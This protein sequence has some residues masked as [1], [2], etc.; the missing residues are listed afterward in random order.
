MSSETAYQGPPP[1][2]PPPPGWRIETVVLPAEP[3]R[4]PA[5]DR[6]AIDA[7]EQR[8]RLVTHWAA[9]LSVAAMFAVVIAGIVRG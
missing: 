7:A 2:D 5:Q 8:A 9:L 1:N 4:M 6:E 3:R